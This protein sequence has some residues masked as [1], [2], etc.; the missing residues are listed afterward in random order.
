LDARGVAFSG[1]RLGIPVV[2]P[3]TRAHC[4]DRSRCVSVVRAG[5]YIQPSRNKRIGGQVSRYLTEHRAV[6]HPGGREKFI[7]RHASFLHEV[8]VNPPQRISKFVQVR[9]LHSRTIVRS[10]FVA[11]NTRMCFGRTNAA[12][13]HESDDTGRPQGRCRPS[14]VSLILRATSDVRL[15]V[16]RRQASGKNFFAL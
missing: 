10:G 4:R 16:A 2:V 8:L 12:R 15:R 11:F 5:R 9:P 1:R 6:G 3:R 13:S 7:R 14:Y